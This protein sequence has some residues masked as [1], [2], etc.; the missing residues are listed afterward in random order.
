MA[1]NS[2]SIL[3]ISEVNPEHLVLISNDLTLRARIAD[4]I[5]ASTIKAALFPGRLMYA[6][7]Q[8]G[9]LYLIQR[10]GSIIGAAFVKY[11]HQM[12]CGERM[13][14]TNWAVLY[15]FGSDDAH[16]FTKL[17]EHIHRE[18]AKRKVRRFYLGKKLREH[19]IKRAR[20]SLIDQTIRILKEQIPVL[21]HDPSPV[22]LGFYK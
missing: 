18:A 11:V 19:P 16:A 7:T 4:W 6:I 13:G 22:E 8:R 21:E 17:Y 9:Y 2:E 1:D 20:L 3:H 15:G 5:G 12:R 14:A 10:D